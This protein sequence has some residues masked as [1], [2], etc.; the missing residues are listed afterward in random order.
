MK[1]LFLLIVFLLALSVTGRAATISVQSATVPNWQ[2]TAAPVLYVFYSD[3]F[4]A[5]DGTV[6]VGGSPQRFNVF[7]KVACS[8]SAG[9]VTI[10]AFTILSTR[11]GLD[12]N[13]VQVSFYFYTTQG[14]LISSFGN[15]V[16]LSIPAVIASLSG[17]SPAGTCATFADLKI[18]NE[19]S[20]SL[21]PDQYYSKTQVDQKITGY[22]SPLTTKGDL[23]THNGTILGR[24]PVGTDAQVLIAD[25]TQTLGL[26]WGAS[27]GGSPPAG[28]GS[29]LQARLN[30][31]T[32]QALM[33]SS[34]SGANLTLGGGIGISGTS[35]TARRPLNLVATG[36]NQTA[37]GGDYF[38]D[39]IDISGGGG[40]AGEHLIAIDL[41]ATAASN[42]PGTGGLIGVNV[43]TNVNAGITSDQVQNVNANTAVSGIAN[44]VWGTFDQVATTG[45]GTIPLSATAA[46]HDIVAAGGAINNPTL[47]FGRIRTLATGTITGTAKGIDLSGWSGA[48]A[49][50]YGIYADSSIDI[51]T[52]KYFIYSLSASP[53]LLTGDLTVSG[54]LKAG[55]GPTTHT[56]AAGKILAAA[57]ATPTGSGNWVLA[58]SPAIAGG[59]HTGLTGLGIRS[60]GTGAFDLTLANVENLTVARTL[61]IQLG[62]AARTLILGASPSLSGSNTG[63]QTITLTGDV[64][65][66]GT[67]SFAATI[68]NAA[69]TYAKIQNVSTT[70]RVLGRNTAG[71]GATEELATLPNGV[72]D[73]I[74][75]LGTVTLG[76]WNGTA[77]ANANLANS[78]ITSNAGTN[79]GM[80]APGSVALGGT[81]VFGNAADNLRF[82]GLGLGVAAPTTAG[83]IA[84]T[85]GA[86]NVT[87]LLIK[88][89]TDT[90]PTGK[91]FDFQNAAAASLASMDI[92]GN[93][94]VVSCTGCGGGGSPGGSGSELQA[95]LT[96]TTFQAVANSS[97]TASGD[98]A[99]APSIH[100][101]GSPT[102]FKITSPADTTLTLS[103]E[104]VGVDFNLAATR[105]FATGA[106]TTQREVVFRA[107]TYGFVAASTITNA[108]TLA[109]T[110]APIA[111]TNATLTNPYAFWIQ[112]GTSRFDGPLGINSTAASAFFVG[113]NADTNPVLRVVDNVASAATGLS[114]TG[115][116][117]G[118]GVT[119][120]VLSSGTNEGII[121]AAK[122]NGGGLQAFTFQGGGNNLV[123]LDGNLGGINLYFSTSYGW[124]N[125][126]SGAAKDTALSRNAAG[127]VEINNGTAGQ[128]GSLVSGVR[129][130]GTTT[131]TN[132]LTIGHQSTGTPAA[133]LGSAIRFNINSSTTADQNAAQIAALWTDAAHATRTADIILSNVN[134]AA[135]LAEVARFKANADVLINE[136]GNGQSFALQSKTELLAIA[137]AATSSTTFTVPAGAVVYAVSVR[138]TVAIPT[139]ATFTVTINGTGG[140]K[141]FNTVAV[142]VAINTTDAGTAAGAAYQG[143]TAQSVVITPS[144]TPGTNA[145]R[146]RVTAYYYLPVVPAS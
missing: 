8:L 75:R 79:F 65:G 58:T 7:K 40:T 35:P 38:A 62:D 138:V 66:S 64:T 101:S 52:T 74:T 63:D 99:L 142:P 91:F 84:S 141:T 76:V 100:T 25:S 140:L 144:A 103:A 6:V 47:F 22:I 41:T 51:G 121:I 14:A 28:S 105:Q 92:A 12:K 73:N 16:D 10:P 56:D 136:G 104:S 70:A 114:I 88:R 133:G 127:I 33:G 48:P 95:R 90:A 18:Y 57:A 97:I 59:S 17:C 43:H 139:A 116:A 123:S 102:F 69:V 9:T 82:N 26:R 107:P 130:A 39:H 129:D 32:L 122:G 5:A 80:T 20:P 1:R 54:L 134:S 108:A 120:S 27:G 145:G 19:G 60:T 115:N 15:Y 78:T 29:E 137:A 93:L 125:G 23:Q 89:F 53:S 34:I 113:P 42:M 87:G 135:A 30:A 2:R 45:T 146:V 86:N 50:S 11:D 128:W 109:I 55:S 36:I 111:G 46:F 3:T 118:S 4:T 72:Q 68:A 85:L 31:S 37:L 98:M 67:G 96:G 143:T 21:P 44:T 126:D 71:A 13:S 119:L 83:Q 110:G 77:I 61:T 117:A 49:T 24:L 106:L 124:G 81:G 131:I 132:G 94:T 112:A